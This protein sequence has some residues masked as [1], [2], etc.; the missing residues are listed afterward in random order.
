MSAIALLQVRVV[1]WTTTKQNASYFG[2]RW[3]GEEA[4]MWGKQPAMAAGFMY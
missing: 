2:K 3:V 4:G 1:G